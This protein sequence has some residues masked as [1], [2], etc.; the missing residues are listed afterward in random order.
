MQVRL[1]P[2][3]VAVACSEHETGPVC[4]LLQDRADGAVQLCVHEDHV[5][6]AVDRLQDDP[7]RRLEAPGHLDQ[8]VDRWRRTD[9]ARVVGDDEAAS[10]DRGLELGEAVHLGDV[11]GARLEVRVPGVRDGSVRDC[12]EANPAEDAQE[13]AGDPAPHGPGTDHRHPDR[14]PLCRT[15]LEEAI[16]DHHGRDSRSGHASSLAEMTLTGNGQS[17]PS[18]GSSHRIP[19]SASGV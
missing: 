18:R 5:L 10:G 17:I 6:A 11:G 3:L 9:Q 4:T 8:R 12:H 2:R 14:T 1:D 16:D 19:R 7:C 13:L 15:L